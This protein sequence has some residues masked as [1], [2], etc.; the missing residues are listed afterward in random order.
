MKLSELQALAAREHAGASPGE[1]F[2]EAR[3]L[4]VRWRHG[5][6]FIDGAADVLGVLLAAAEALVLSNTKALRIQH[7]QRPSDYAGQIGAVLWELEATAD[8]LALAKAFAH[9]WEACACAGVWQHQVRAA[10]ARRLIEA[11]LN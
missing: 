2:T 11:E 5:A 9:F 3:G 6:R 4:C 1:L 10:C 7:N 8:P